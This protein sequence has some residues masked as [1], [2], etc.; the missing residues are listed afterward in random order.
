[1]TPLERRTV[2]AEAALAATVLHR[3][4][5]A[6]TRALRHICLEALDLA[7]A[8]YFVE[9][10]ALPAGALV[11]DRALFERLIVALWVSRSDENA[12]RFMDAAKHETAR[13]LRKF[14]DSGV[15]ALV[16]EKYW[17]RC[18]RGTAQRP[19]VRR[20]QTLPIL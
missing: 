14:I 18:H 19:A 7:K 4:R 2:D 1:M 3:E 12:E 17:R 11:L 8:C 5:D 15:G 9:M 16:R 10:A 13:Q 6:R 20:N